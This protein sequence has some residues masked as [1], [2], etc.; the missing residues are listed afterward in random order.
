FSA[1]MTP[2]SA[3]Q[4][5]AAQFERLEGRFFRVDGP[6]LEPAGAPS[7]SDDESDDDTNFIVRGGLRQSTEAAADSFA[8]RQ[9]W[10]KRQINSVVFYL[11]QWESHEDLTWEP[12]HNL[13]LD[14]VARFEASH[15]HSVW[16]YQSTRG[17]LRQLRAERPTRRSTRIRARSSLRRQLG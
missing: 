6:N 4:R 13:P 14:L 16:A 5:H 2:L 9:L 15:K 12:T 17:R 10:A 11:V 1:V 7:H 8:V 3:G